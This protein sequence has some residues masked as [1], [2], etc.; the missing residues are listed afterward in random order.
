MRYLGPRQDGAAQLARIR[1]HWEQYGF[2]LW[3]VDEKE[4]GAFVGRVGLSLHR[5]WPDDP[6]VGWGLAPEHWGRGYATEAGGAALRHA[7][8]TLD[9]AR[10]VSIVHPENGAS[11]RVMDRLGITP[12]R[13][14]P[15]DDTGITLEVRAIERDRWAALQSGTC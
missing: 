4:T 10:V 9:L 8:T 15:W 6:E 5:L 2:G 13:E 11:I 12:W 1:R 7:F 14:V 3:A